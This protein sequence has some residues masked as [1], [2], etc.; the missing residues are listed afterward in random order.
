VRLRQQLSLVLLITLEA[1]ASDP[2]WRQAQTGY[3]FEFPRDHASHPE[4]KFEWW[5]YT[6]N[7]ATS[8]GQ[9]FGYQLTFF[10]VGVDRKP[11]NPSRWAVRDLYMT[12]FAITDV[13][14]GRYR[15]AERMNR[16]GIGWAGAS[17]DEYH[18]WNQDWEVKLCQGKHQLRA[19]EGEMALTLELE[20]GKPPVIHGQQGISQKGSQPGNASHYYSLTRMPTRGELSLGGKRY[21]VGGLSWMDHEFGTS[22]LEAEQI[23]WDWFSIQLD[24]GVELM[25]FQLRRSDGTLDR[26]S[27]GTWIEADGKHRPLKLS[28]FTLKVDEVWRSP[29]SGAAYPV[30]WRVEIPR[31]NLILNVRAVLLDQ[32]LRTER[33]TGVNYWEGAVEVSG[34]RA[35]R[36]S[37]G[38]GYLEMTGYSGKPISEKFR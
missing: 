27:S 3:S 11:K 16:S 32:E 37:R 15:F 9:R 24:G 29:K 12:H 26:H 10:R 20:E 18:V 13:S 28:E 25:V 4:Y 2:A 14:G 35:Q 34:N 30:A 22:F 17:T 1:F 8:E 19:T 31:E 36:L 6:G 21:V 38:R 7:L 23:G 33:S 5:Y